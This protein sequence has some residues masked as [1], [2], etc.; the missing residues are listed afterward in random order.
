MIRCYS[1]HQYH[2]VCTMPD[3]WQGTRP[4][5][6]RLCLR[7]SHSRD[8]GATGGSEHSAGRNVLGR[9]PADAGGRMGGRLECG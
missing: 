7:D 5:Q 6:I 2:R 8:R 4:L 9:T 1:L 3:V